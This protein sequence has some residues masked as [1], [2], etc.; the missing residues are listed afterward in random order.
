MRRSSASRRAWSFNPRPAPKCRATPK[1]HS[2]TGSCEVSIRAR[3]LNAERPSRNALALCSWRFN[4][5]PAPKCRATIMRFGMW[6]FPWGCF[7]P[8]PAPKCRA[9]CATFTLAYPGCVSIRARH[10]NAE[11][12]RRS[13][14][15][16]RAARF[17]PRPAPKC[18][19]TSGGAW[20]SPASPKFQS[21][22][23]T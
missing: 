19:A 23:G 13:S 18:R 8:R 21:A 11:R 5:R 15:P 6:G 20:T 4:P 1:R 17:N 10:L 22:P 7:N 2:R 3:H 16:A 14:A 9:T 12:H